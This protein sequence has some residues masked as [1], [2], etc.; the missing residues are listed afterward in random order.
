[1]PSARSGLK[2]FPSCSWRA[3]WLNA[4]KSCWCGSQ[5]V[6]EPTSSSDTSEEYIADSGQFEPVQYGNN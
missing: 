5:A 4:A 6:A 2:R 3:V 1:M